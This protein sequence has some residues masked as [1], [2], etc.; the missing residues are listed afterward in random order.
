MDKKLKAAV[1]GKTVVKAKAAIPDGYTIRVI[2]EDGEEFMVTMEKRNNRIN[3][4]VKKGIITKIDG[5][6]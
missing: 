1:L 2:E 6:Y 5:V 4:V 3:V